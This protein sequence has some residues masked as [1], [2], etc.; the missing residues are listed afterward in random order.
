MTQLPRTGAPA[1][2]PDR[3]V[4][5]EP[6]SPPGGGTVTLRPFAEPDRAA[7]LGM[8]ARSRA[9]VAPWIPLNETGESDDA[10]FVRKAH[11]RSGKST[12]PSSLNL[13][14]PAAARKAC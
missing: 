13:E 3:A 2:L 12:R 14:R 10:F 7:F 11:R 5:V 1:P 4:E 8:L 6:S 9:S